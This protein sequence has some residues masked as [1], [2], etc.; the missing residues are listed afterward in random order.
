M[1]V[2]SRGAWTTQNTFC[3]VLHFVETSFRDHIKIKVVN[4]EQVVLERGVSV[5]TFATQ[6]PPIA[7]YMFEEG[8]ATG[9]GLRI[10]DC[11]SQATGKVKGLPRPHRT[12]PLSCSSASIEELFQNPKSNA[13]LKILLPGVFTHPRLDE[14][15]V[16]N[17]LQS[18]SRYARANQ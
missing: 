11:I 1:K 2:V 16:C 18:Y 17:S 15:K 4:H 10:S 5:N 6:R 12:E 9:T 13:I 7:A 14:I 3:I 8:S